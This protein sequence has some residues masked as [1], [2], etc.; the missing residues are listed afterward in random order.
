MQEILD[1][2]EQKRAA[3]R[4]GGG[5]KRIAAQHAKGKLTARERLEVLLDEGTF[6]EWDMF[7]EHRCVDSMAALAPKGDSTADRTGAAQGGGG[8]PRAFH[9]LHAPFA[10]DATRA[11]AVE[12]AVRLQ[13][14]EATETG[15]ASRVSPTITV[16]FPSR[17]SSP[18]GLPVT[19]GSPNTP[20]RS[21][22][23]WKASPSGI[24]KS[25]KP[26][27]SEALEPPRAAPIRSGAS[28]EYLAVL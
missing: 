23:N 4:L 10:L 12:Q 14:L 25:L 27:R 3:A 2:L 20:S 7:V 21:S 26:L 1:Q 17:R 24:P 6:E 9:E 13:S 11:Q 18:A 16:R 8:E 22:R 15:S 19:S 5:E 28:R